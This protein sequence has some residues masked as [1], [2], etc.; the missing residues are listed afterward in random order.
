MDVHIIKNKTEELVMGINTTDIFDALKKSGKAVADKAGELTDIAKSNIDL[1][2]AKSKLEDL[3]KALGKTAYDSA[4]GKES[5]EDLEQML[6]K[7]D[8]Q[9][10]VVNDL[11]NKIHELNK[12]KVCQSCGKKNDESASY[13]VN[14]GTKL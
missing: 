2:N 12:V 4:R 5:G 9:L 1:L 14:C 10:N 3:Y 8:V 6:E 7:I 13:C 11:Q